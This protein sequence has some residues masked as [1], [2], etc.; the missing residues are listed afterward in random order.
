MIKSNTNGGTSCSVIPQ[1]W[2]FLTSYKKLREKFLKNETWNIV[3]RLGVKGFQTPMWDFN[4]MLIA[5]SH[6]PTDENYTF[7]GLDVSDA[8]NATAKEAAIK[9]AELKQVKQKEQLGNPEVRVI[10]D[11]FKG[12]SLLNTN[13]NSFQGIKS[14]DDQR[15]RFSFWEI[16]EYS[17]WKPLQSTVNRKL[18]LRWFK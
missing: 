7:S 17:L 1:N 2:L 8:P 14:G 6:I 12:Q 10:L 18:S 11:D 15:Y 9:T 13:A 4:V 3:A 5:I 16:N